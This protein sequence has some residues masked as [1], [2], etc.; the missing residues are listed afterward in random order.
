MQIILVR[1]AVV[2]V[3]LAMPPCTWQL[4]DEGRRG[5]R[6]LARDPIWLPVERIF[7]SPEPKAFETA[8][9]LAGPNGMS[10]TAIEDLHEVER[11]PNQWFGDDYPGGYRGAVTEY[12]SRPRAATHG[13]ET[14][15]V[16]QRR[17]RRC[18]ERLREWEPWGF[19]VAGH[20]LTLSLYIASVTGLDPAQ[21]WPAIGLPDYA[22]LDLDA[23]ALVVPFGAHTRAAV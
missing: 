22:V 18:I 10:V 13:W 21:I 19:A 7:S 14:P 11:P 4:S 12:F 17:M 23:A 8:H 15:R 1:H 9:I 5:A 3:D 20:G 2:D 16:A 6:L